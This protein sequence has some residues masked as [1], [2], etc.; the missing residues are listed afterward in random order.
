MGT[1][2]PSSAAR[3]PG[4]SWAT[5]RRPA[6]AVAA[7]KRGEVAPEDLSNNLIVQLGTVTEH[8]NRHWYVRNTGQVVTGVQRQVFHPVKRWTWNGPQYKLMRIEGGARLSA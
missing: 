1:A 8:L 3:M 5:T 7:K 4:S 2:A 6:P